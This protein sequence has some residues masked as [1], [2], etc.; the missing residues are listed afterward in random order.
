MC[1]AKIRIILRYEI[2]VLIGGVHY[3]TV[4]TSHLLQ[5]QSTVVS[6]LVFRHR[7]SISQVSC[8]LPDHRPHLKV[9]PLI[10]DRTKLEDDESNI[11]FKVGI[12]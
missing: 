9:I 8:S 4:N 12:A 2:S 7:V 6:F 5:G 10:C 3:S 11:C 1:K